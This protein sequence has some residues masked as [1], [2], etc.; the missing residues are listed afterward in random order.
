MKTYTLLSNYSG[1]PMPFTSTEQ[2]ASSYYANSNTQTV[3]TTGTFVATVMLQ[4]TL[5]ENPTNSDFFDIQT[6]SSSGSVNI[7]GNFTYIRAKVTAYTSGTI[8]STLSY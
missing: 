1:A 7:S 5:V 4:G 8:T 2:K 3:A 6:I